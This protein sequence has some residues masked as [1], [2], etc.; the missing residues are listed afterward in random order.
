MC[1]NLK[2]AVRSDHSRKHATPPT[3]RNALRSDIDASTA[4][5]GRSLYYPDFDPVYLEQVVV[6]EGA[7]V[8]SGKRATVEKVMEFG[9]EIGAS[10]GK[11]TKCVKVE[12]TSG[13]YH[14]RPITPVAYREK[15]D[16]QVPCCEDWS[17]AR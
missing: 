11:P 1:Q 15:M 10:E 7:Y 16:R 2:E 5:G 6:T 9:D 14:G 4:D 3:L 8:A 17:S 13:T 12:C